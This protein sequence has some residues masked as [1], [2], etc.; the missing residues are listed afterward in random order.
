MSKS[1]RTYT[2]LQ[3]TTL[4]N[5]R[6]NGV[7]NKRMKKLCDEEI[8][9]DTVFRLP[10]MLQTLDFLIMAEEHFWE[11]SK[12]PSIFIESAQVAQRLFEATYDAKWMDGIQMPF[13][14][15]IL[16]MP[17]D[18][19]VNDTIIPGC[20]VTWMRF[21]DLKDKA[22]TPLCK[23]AGIPVPQEVTVPE[24]Y[25]ESMTI[26]ISYQDPYDNRKHTYARIV[27]P[28][29]LFGS[30]LASKNGQEFRQRAGDYK[31]ASFKGL[32]PSSD[33]D[34][35]IQFTLLKLVLALAVFNQATEQ[36]HLTPGLPGGHIQVDGVVRNLRPVHRTLSMPPLK[37]PDTKGAVEDHYR[38]FHFRQLRHE[39]YYQ[40]EYAEWAP[41]TRWTFVSDAWITSSGKEIDPYT[42]GGDQ[43]SPINIKTS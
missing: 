16:S 31:D 10:D 22:I 25:R 7:I 3:Q 8:L 17:K 35:T 19:T 34:L 36:E 40:G 12:R 2:P 24:Q 32:V 37:A 6:R 1:F 13:D 21:C 15:F 5:L 11:L 30:V 29:D 38:S 39:R 9:G 20:M 33:L 41:G 18:F 14:S 28:S 27:I 43:L 26:H 4:K 42:Q 23:K